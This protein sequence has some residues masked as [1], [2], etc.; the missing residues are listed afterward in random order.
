MDFNVLVVIGSMERCG[1][2]LSDVFN[3]KAS[4]YMSS[5]PNYSECLFDELY[6][7]YGWSEQTIVADIGALA[8]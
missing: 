8:L 1:N 7:S 4:F 5:R 3:G 6:S 2:V